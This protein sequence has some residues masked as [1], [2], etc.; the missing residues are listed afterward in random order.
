MLTKDVVRFFKKRLEIEEV[1][2]KSLQKAVQKFEPLVTNGYYHFFLNP[3]TFLHTITHEKH[4]SHALSTIIYISSNITPIQNDKSRTNKHSNPKKTNT[5]IVA[6]VK[7]HQYTAHA[8]SMYIYYLLFF[9]LKIY[10]RATGCLL[11]RNSS[12]DRSASEF[13]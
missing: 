6:T 3:Y 13:A 8:L 1:Y 7:Y 9:I 2:C 10:W 5:Q 4:H 11:D 12:R